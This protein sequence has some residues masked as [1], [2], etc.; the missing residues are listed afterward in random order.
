[1]KRFFI[2]GLILLTLLML[3]SAALKAEASSSLIVK[4]S[5]HNTTCRVTDGNNNFAYQTIN[6]DGSYMLDEIRFMIG[7]RNTVAMPDLDFYFTKNES[8]I[9]HN[10]LID[11]SAISVT[12]SE[13][14]VT[15]SP[16]EVDESDYYK[17]WW[18][19]DGIALGNF[20]SLR[21][22]NSNVYTDGFGGCVSSG[23]DDSNIGDYY[24]ALYGEKNIGFNFSWLLPLVPHVL[25]TTSCSFV[26][27]GPTTTAQCSDPVLSSSS[28]PFFLY[29]PSQVLFNGFLLFVIAFAGL[30]TL[31]RKFKNKG[32]DY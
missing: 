2:L 26:T 3:A 4:Q 27:L 14:I 21:Y 30:F 12:P 16:I 7:K 20:Y 32:G 29:N 1:M 8:T 23:V 19:V 31:W 17:L 28:T 9:L 6:F 11:D 24:F 10:V 5:S 13:Y 25:A 15:F 22:A 18:F